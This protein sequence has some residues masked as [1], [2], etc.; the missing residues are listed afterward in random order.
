LGPDNHNGV[1]RPSIDAILSDQAARTVLL[2]WQDRLRTTHQLKRYAE[3]CLADA[4]LVVGA[5]WVVSANFRHFGLNGLALAVRREVLSVLAGLAREKRCRLRSLLPLSGTAYWSYR[6]TGENGEVCLLLHEPNRFTVLRYLGRSLK[7]V[8]VEPV[9]ASQDG[10]S[11]DRLLRRQL[12]QGSPSRID[13][14]CAGQEKLENKVLAGLAR[15]ARI[16]DL[17][18]SYLG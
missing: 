5:D 2:P 14:W 12:A 9:V 16:R 6:P 4:G 3:A 11:V 18:R 13:Y 1:W 8:D 10:R 15:G 17:P 7:S